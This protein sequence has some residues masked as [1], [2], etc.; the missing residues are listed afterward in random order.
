MSLPIPPSSSRSPWWQYALFVLGMVLV[1]LV[2]IPSPPGRKMMSAFY[3]SRVLLLGTGILAAVYFN[4]KILVPRF[5]DKRRF[6]WY[7]GTVIVL[8][9]GMAGLVFLGNVWAFN[10]FATKSNSPISANVTA[11]VA[12][13]GGG[14]ENEMEPRGAPPA[15][16]A[17]LAGGRPAG[18]PPPPPPP[19]SGQGTGQRVA[20]G[21]D[22]GPSP[23]GPMS[24]TRRIL[25]VFFL[26]IGGFVGLSSLL[27]ALKSISRTHRL[28]RQKLEAEMTALRAQLNPHFLFN[29][30]N[31]IYSLALD[32][33]DLAPDYVLKLSELMRYILH[34]CQADEVPLRKELEFVQNYLDLERIRMEDTV[35]LELE[36]DGPVDDMTVAPLMLLPF[37]ENAFKH[38]I[39]TKPEGAFVKITVKVDAMEVLDIEAINSKENGVSEADLDLNGTVVPGGVGLENVRRRLALLYPHRHKLTLRDAGSRYE[40]NL[41]IT[42]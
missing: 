5:L 12:A 1:L 19:G 17:Q 4:L 3:L 20:G 37:V 31:N 21:G 7:G 26:E 18:G 36:V 15:R 41:Q 8:I 35:R 16:G 34:D 40:V 32:K 42:P 39:K 27:H 29:S 13:D 11:A 2:L 22:N 6:G 24:D 10:K 30:L 14:G 23:G 38:G 25:V 28:E 33:S 9:A